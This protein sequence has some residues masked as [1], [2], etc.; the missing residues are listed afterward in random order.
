MI[1]IYVFLF[2]FVVNVAFIVGFKG[3]ACLP[4]RSTMQS[5]QL[6]DIPT[7]CDGPG[8][9]LVRQLTPRHTMYQDL[10]KSTICD[11]VVETLS[12]NGVT[13]ENKTIHT[14]PFKVRVFVVLCR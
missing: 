13:S 4:A 12:S 14:A 3:Y 1:Y 2:V 11:K 6:C 5:R 10:L 8:K 7:D 9:H